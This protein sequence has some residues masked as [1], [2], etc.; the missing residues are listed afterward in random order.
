MWIYIIILVFIV[1]LFSLRPHEYILFNS[2]LPKVSCDKKDN[3]QDLII[4]PPAPAVSLVK[5]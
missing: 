3:I 4:L 2:Q 1:C 5:H